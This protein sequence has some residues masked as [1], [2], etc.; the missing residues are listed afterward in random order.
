MKKKYTVLWLVLVLGILLGASVDAVLVRHYE[1]GNALNL[2]EATIGPDASFES[3]ATK[4]PRPGGFN[5][6]IDLSALAK[7][8][9]TCTDPT[10]WIV[11]I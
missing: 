11:S 10:G 8:W 9:I 1:F 7:N 3:M 5:S 4:I 6:A 2:G